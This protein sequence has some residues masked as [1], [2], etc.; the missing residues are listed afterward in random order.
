M[1]NS[2]LTRKAM[3]EMA[4]KEQRKAGAKPHMSS[5]LWNMFTGS[6]PYLEMFRGTLHPGFIYNLVLSLFSAVWPGRKNVRPKTK[7]A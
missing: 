2:R 1:K 6:A 5:L 4:Q 7:V 3:L